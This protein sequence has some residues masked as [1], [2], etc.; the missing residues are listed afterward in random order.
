MTDSLLCTVRSALVGMTRYSRGLRRTLPHR[1]L[2]LLCLLPLVREFLVLENVRAVRLG[3]PGDGGC[4]GRAV[5]RCGGGRTWLSSGQRGAPT[6]YTG[7]KSRR[8]RRIQASEAFREGPFP[9]AK[10]SPF[11][12]CCRITTINKNLA[13]KFIVSFFHWKD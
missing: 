6:M 4:R 12:V 13:K 5:R 9:A 2:N 8:N 7:L 11:F 10:R 1:N 3:F